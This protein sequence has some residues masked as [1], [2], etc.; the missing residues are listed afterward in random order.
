MRDMQRLD[1]VS[2]KSLNIY[3]DDMIRLLVFEN[4]DFSESLSKWK[5]FLISTVL[6]LNKVTGLT[7]EDICQDLLTSLS[8][9]HMMQG[10][11]LYRYNK[12]IY[13]VVDETSDTYRLNSIPGNQNKRD[14]WVNKEEVEVV[15][16]A[17]LSSL[18]YKK[19]QQEASSII[20][21]NFTQKNGYRRVEIKNTVVCLKTTNQWDKNNTREIT[22]SFVKS[23]VEVVYDFGYLPFQGENNQEE[24]VLAN[25]FLEHLRGENKYLLADMLKYKYNNLSCTDKIIKGHFKVS[26]K[27]L[28]FCKRDLIKEFDRFSGEN[29]VVSSEVKPIQ[30]PESVIK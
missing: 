10:M 22:E 18:F 21:H 3:V 4:K 13:L 19:I 12:Q 27:K 11:D 15:K 26:W 16:K 30:L 6:K 8:R 25:M 9:V 2:R 29:L 1:Q 24:M 28:L 20:R 17:K 23:V 14:L 7:C 5:P